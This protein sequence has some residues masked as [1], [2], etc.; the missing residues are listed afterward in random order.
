[1]QRRI[2]GYVVSGVVLTAVLWWPAWILTNGPMAHFFN[3][4]FQTI[5]GT[6]AVV[7]LCL[8]TAGALVVGVWDLTK[9]A[10]S[11]KYRHFHFRPLMHH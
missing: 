5:Y 3:N 6:F 10:P 1:M 11:E 9:D 8:V 7:L 4:E 2:A